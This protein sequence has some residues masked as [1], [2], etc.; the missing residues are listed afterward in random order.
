MHPLLYW[1]M[2]L[3]IPV[4]LISSL[5]SSNL[6]VDSNLRSE[7]LRRKVDLELAIKL[8][9]AEVLAWSLSWPLYRRSSC[10]FSAVA[11]FWF[12]R[13]S[14]ASWRTARSWARA[15]ELI[16]W[17]SDTRS[18]TLCGSWSARWAF[19]RRNEPLSVRDGRSCSA[20][21]SRSTCTSD[22]KERKFLIDSKTSIFISP[23][24]ASEVA[25]SLAWNL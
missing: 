15:C 13:D 17:S 23:I 5:I 7:R 10:G 12:C 25:S 11:G 2:R 22:Y 24:D 19:W 8:T 16:W 9:L 14:A 4:N 18:D 1:L 3:M 6:T 20:R 21:S